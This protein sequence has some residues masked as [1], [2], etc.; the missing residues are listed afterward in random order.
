MN[1]KPDTH[2]T[3]A[4]NACY[5]KFFCRVS[6]RQ[7]LGAAVLVAGWALVMADLIGTT[8]SGAPASSQLVQQMVWNPSP[9]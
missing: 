9:K 6:P 8:P 7:L 4:V 3:H 2:G 1:R 5:G